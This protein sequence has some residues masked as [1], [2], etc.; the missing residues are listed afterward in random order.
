MVSNSGASSAGDNFGESSG[1]ESAGAVVV[2]AGGSSRMSG[3][4]KIFAPL[5]GIPLL[6]HVLDQL[7]AFA[8]VDQ[9]ALVMGKDSVKRGRELVGL[10]LCL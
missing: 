1:G 9:I 5:L 4:D 10:V 3:I 2:A 8:P 6:A 7:E